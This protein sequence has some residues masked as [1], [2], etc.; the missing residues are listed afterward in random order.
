MPHTNT[1]L[2]ENQDWCLF[3]CPNGTFV[4]M[5]INHC[6]MFAVSLDDS[7]C[8][9]VSI[10]N[11]SGTPRKPTEKSCGLTFIYF[12]LFLYFIMVYIKC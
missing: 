7:T 5:N 4:R 10:F 3:C 9:G 1:Y 2:S 11:N 12:V 6:S 8:G